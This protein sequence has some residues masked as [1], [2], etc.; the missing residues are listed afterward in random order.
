MTHE[1]KH[2]PLLDWGLSSKLLKL[3]GKSVDRDEL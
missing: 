1:V 3:I 2:C